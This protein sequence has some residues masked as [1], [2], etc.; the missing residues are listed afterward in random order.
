MFSLNNSHVFLK[1]QPLFSLSNNLVFLKQ[2]PLF[3]LNNSHCFS[4]FYSFFP[5]V[6][7][8]LIF[9]NCSRFFIQIYAQ[10]KR[11]VQKRCAYLLI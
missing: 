8:L 1:Q 3:S 5:L 6:F 9:I 7:K 11:F 2:Q 4:L 10:S